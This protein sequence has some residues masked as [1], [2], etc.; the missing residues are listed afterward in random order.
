MDLP[1]LLQRIPSEGLDAVY[2][3]LIALTYQRLERLA[4]RMLRGFPVL[5]GDHSTHTVLH[6]GLLRF[7]GALRACEPVSE[8]EFLGL[9]ALQMRRV[10][11][12]LVRAARRRQRLI[13][14]RGA[15]GAAFD[16]GCETHDPARLA[17]WGEFHRLAGALP[18]PQRAVFNLCFYHGLTQEAA[19]ARLGISQKTVSDRWRAALRTLKKV[20][21][22]LP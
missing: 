17:C 8:E 19:G 4:R 12:D 6:E 9:A 15:D 1:T 16:P 2:D 20:I 18:E 11:V 22:Q 5:V 3:D 13:A 21:E 7:P 10:L 14:P